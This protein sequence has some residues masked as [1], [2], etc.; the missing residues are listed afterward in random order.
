[1]VPLTTFVPLKLVSLAALIS[2]IKIRESNTDRPAKIENE[3]ENNLENSQNL[4]KL[5]NTA[6]R[7]LGKTKGSNTNGRSKRS[8]FKHIGK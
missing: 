4:Y 2:F 6:F 3:S 5:K 1:M 8:P 7:N